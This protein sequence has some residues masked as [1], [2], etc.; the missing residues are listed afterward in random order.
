MGIFLYEILDPNAGWRRTY[1]P[2]NDISP[3]LVAATI[4]TEDKDFYSHGGFDPLAIVRA[5]WENI[6]SG[7]TVSGASTITQQLARLAL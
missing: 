1:V 3:N 5:F 4:S 2:L 6:T 7:E